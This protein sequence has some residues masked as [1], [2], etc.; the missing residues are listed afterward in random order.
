MKILTHILAAASG[1]AV[2]L[3]W[4]KQPSPHVTATGHQKPEIPRHR[5][6][7]SIPP[8]ARERRAPV[9]S[10]IS[11][12]VSRTDFDSWITSKEGDPRSHAEA[13]VITGMLTKDPELV[14]KGIATDPGNAD[15]LF[16]GA[17]LPG[18][19]KEER[20][21]LSKRLIAADPDN[22]LSGFVGASLLLEAGQSKEALDVLKRA[23]T[24]KRTSDYRFS[25]ELL[26]EDA[27]LAAGFSPESAKI[28][29]VIEH[30]LPYLS[31]L[32]NL[33]TSLK[34]MEATMSP[35]ESAD[36]R[37]MAARMGQQISNQSRSGLVI[38]QLMGLSLEEKLLRGLPD[39]A[40]SAY[41]GMT[42]GEARESLAE[43]RL[44][45]KKALEGIE[46]IQ[47]LYSSDPELMSRYLD[48]VRLVGELEAARWLSK[49]R[50]SKK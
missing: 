30:G 45:I 6:S 13:M 20:L 12:A 5:S 1:A 43:E 34:E 23:T 42:V 36:L 41:E 9:A 38:N 3:L 17:T 37:A 24:L 14:R 33:A 4:P 2:V 49:E 31:D 46:D 44:Q 28:R 32:S 19:P 35:E 11:R 21:T 18:F 40:P 39:E 22:A 25:T 8:S 10:E 47:D 48:R 50:E 16:I 27:Y 29:S 26:T 15:L 7:D